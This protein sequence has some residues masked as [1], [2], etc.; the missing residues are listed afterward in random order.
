MI[1][2]KINVA[3]GAGNVR[4]THVALLESA[5]VVSRRAAL[6]VFGAV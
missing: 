2:A 5:L 1:N 6:L 3:A 4:N